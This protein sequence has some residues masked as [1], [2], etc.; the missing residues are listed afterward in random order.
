MISNSQIEERLIDVP[1]GT[2]FAR[3]WTPEHVRSKRPV[4]LL[5]DSLG[6]VDLWRNFPNLLAQQL[7]APVIAYDRLG[8][9]RSSRR[10]TLPTFEFIAEE[11]D[12]FFPEVHRAFVTDRFSLFGHSVG[13]AMALMIA[14]SP[15]ND[16]CAV[17][18]ESAQAFVEQRTK[19]GI[20]TAK[21]QFKDAAQFDRLKRWHGDKAQWVL[22]AWTETWLSPEF[23]N[24]SLDP[25]LRRVQ[26]PCLVIHGDSDQ[27]G[28]E[29]FP[30][31]IASGTQGPAKLS[32][33]KAC[34]HVPH[35]EQPEKVLSLVTQFISESC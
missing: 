5:H 26:C 8:F 28:S 14:A 25:H 9:G 30:R 34:G 20:R 24:W 4:I 10:D 12:L 21:E 35:R 2:L 1:G 18:T 31:R 13:G 23:A 19:S 33:L 29:E 15:G 32:I 7:A 11:A 3:K 16:C 22:D 6:C 17:V 27:Y